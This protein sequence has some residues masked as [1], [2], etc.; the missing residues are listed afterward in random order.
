MILDSIEQLA[1][2]PGQKR[3]DLFMFDARTVDQKRHVARC[4]I[5]LEGLSQSPA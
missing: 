4:E 2:L 1:N 5:P 3:F